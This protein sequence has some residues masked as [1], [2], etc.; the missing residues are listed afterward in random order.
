MRRLGFLNFTMFST[1]VEWLVSLKNIFIIDLTVPFFL[2][3]KSIYL[4]SE[5]H[6]SL[7]Y[8]CEIYFIPSVLLI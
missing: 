8:L 2:S 6:Q 5:K 1:Q 3:A 7:Q 4:K